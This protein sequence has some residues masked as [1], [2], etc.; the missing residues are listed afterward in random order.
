MII[1]KNNEAEEIEFQKL[2]ENTTKKLNED[3]KKRPKYYTTRSGVKLETDVLERLKKEA[4]G[5]PFE[6]TIEQVSRQ[7]FPD[8]IAKKYYGIEIKSTKSN[9]W[10]STGSSIIESTRIDSV[11]RIY[12]LFGKL[13]DPIEFRIKPYEDCLSDIVVTHSPRYRIDMELKKGET[14]FDKMEV[15]YDVF[16][17]TEDSINI[18]KQYYRSILKPGQNL[19]WVDSEPIEEQAVSPI[20]RMWNSLDNEEKKELQVKGFCW[21]PEIFGNSSTKF[22][23]F[24]LWLVTQQAVVTTSLRDIYTAGGRA[25]IDLDLIT[26]QNQPQIYYKMYGLKDEIKREIL[27]ATDEQVEEFWGIEPVERSNRIYQWVDLVL[28]YISKDKEKTKESMKMFY[29]IFEL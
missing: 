16:R 21:F 2:V 15:E 27:N 4:K 20:I 23:R 12:L 5:T 22:N 11:K 8:L 10:I 29:D 17:K 1:S 7:R 26:W 9:S 28:G 25:N 13:S 14:I 3:A 18:V 19:W 6:N 24:A